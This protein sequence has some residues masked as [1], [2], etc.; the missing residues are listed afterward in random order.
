MWFGVAIQVLA[1]WDAAPGDFQLL[2][3]G[4]AGDQKAARR[5]SFAGEECRPGGSG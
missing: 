1:S 5:R 2:R 3:A 4:R